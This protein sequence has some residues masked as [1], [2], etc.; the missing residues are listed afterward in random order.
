M[1]LIGLTCSFYWDPI[2][3]MALVWPGYTMWDVPDYKEVWSKIAYGFGV[4]IHHQ[5]GFNEASRPPLCLKW[6]KCILNW[7]GKFCLLVDTIY[8]FG[9][10][11]QTECSLLNMFYAGYNKW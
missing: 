7:G 4:R 6:V 8:I 10:D 5:T 1:P 9:S 11:S 3:D 2:L